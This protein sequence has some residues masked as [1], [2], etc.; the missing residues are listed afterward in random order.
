VIDKDGKVAS[1]NTE[2]NAAEDS[3][4]ILDTVAK[5]QKS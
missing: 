3:K 1:K 2:V 4:A 5:L